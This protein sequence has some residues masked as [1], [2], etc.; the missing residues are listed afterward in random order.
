MQSVRRSRRR[1]IALQ[2]IILTSL[3][4][5]ATAFADDS[6]LAQ[7]PGADV[8][9]RTCSMCHAL[10]H[11][12]QIR[13]NRSDWESTINLMV[14][15]GLQLSDDEKQQAIEYLSA[16]YGFGKPKSSAG[17]SGESAN[18]SDSTGSK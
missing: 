3:G 18:S 6:G 1:R 17:K 2:L 12:T 11:V 7:G 13:K 16:N 15:Y 9:Q 10:D 5:A 4:F 14:T 8:V